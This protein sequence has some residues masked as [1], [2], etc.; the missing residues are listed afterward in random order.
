MSLFFLPSSRYFKDIQK[1]FF[2][3]FPSQT[4][5]EVTVPHCACRWCGDGSTRARIT[6][7]ARELG[8]TFI[9]SPGLFNIA[10]QALLIQKMR[11]REFMTGKH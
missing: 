4:P 10:E 5:S 11:D 3:E 8:V 1:S 2:W 9:S 6:G 7:V